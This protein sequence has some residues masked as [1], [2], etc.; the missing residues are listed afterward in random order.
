[1]AK[2]RTTMPEDL[3]GKCHVVIHTAATAAGAAGAIPLPFADA[4]PIGA[5]QIAM[6]ISLGEVFDLTIGRSMAESIAGLGLATTTGR[7]VVSNLLKVVNP[8][9]G[10]VVAAATALAITE[11][12]GWMLAD[13]FYRI[14]VG[15][16]P[17]KIA[18]AM[19][20]AYNHFNKIKKVKKVNR[21]G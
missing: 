10:S 1:M 20:D 7:F 17:E 12:L 8:P 19:G 15:E 13:D 6:I 3:V 5:T 9:F 14:S 21:N 16:K 2:H 11:S 18:K 4:L